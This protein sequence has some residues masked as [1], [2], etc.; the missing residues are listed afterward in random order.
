MKI[1]IGAQD[2][3]FLNLNLNNVYTRG[4]GSHAGNA[5]SDYLFKTFVA[6]QTN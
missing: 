3:G 1:S 4:R 5:N 2:V 6:P